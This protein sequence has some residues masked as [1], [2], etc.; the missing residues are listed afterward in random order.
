MRDPG[1]N[2][3]RIFILLADIALKHTKNVPATRSAQLYTRVEDFPMHISQI[4]I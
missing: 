4:M 3:K 1:N 2:K